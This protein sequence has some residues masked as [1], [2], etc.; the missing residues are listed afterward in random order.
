MAIK[1]S[2]K[3][4][5][6]FTLF[7]LGDSNTHISFVPHRSSYVHQ[8]RLDGL[9]TLDNYSDGAE[10]K[11]NSGYKNLA[12]IPFPNRISKGRFEWSNRKF[13][14]EVN[15]AENCAALHGFGPKV[16]FKVDR[17]SLAKN[18]GSVT[19]SYLHR[20][21]KQHEHY[22][23]F[24]HFELKLGINTVSK[25]AT[26]QLNATNLGAESAP[27]GLG[28]HPYFLLPGRFEECSLHLPQHEEVVLTNA[29]PRGE[30]RKGQALRSI[31]ADWDNCF[32]LLDRT[33]REVGLK[34]PRYSLSLR[35]FGN[36]RYTQIYV[37]GDKK[38]IAIEP[39][40]CGVNAFNIS[41][42]EVE[43]SPKRTLKT[44]M[45]ISLVVG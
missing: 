43:L 15:D 41:K 10:L 2:R 7:T 23:F 37:P 1:L 3:P 6:D 25:R 34:G 8:I 13:H 12:L 40:T 42:A 18:T 26:W 30:R 33:K 32:A 36:T 35:Q 44:G 31:N 11:R 19:M 29:M 17:F 22:P 16:P 27:V 39:M 5:G 21:N 14:F 28:W 20:M 24:I 38:S 45:E 9:N 4:F